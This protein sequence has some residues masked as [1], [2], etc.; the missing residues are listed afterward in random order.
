MRDGF[1]FTARESAALLG[2]T[3]VSVNSALQRARV[4]IADP[5]PAPSSDPRMAETVRL[6]LEAVEHD[7]IDGF[8]EMLRG[9]GPAAERHWTY[10]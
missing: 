5:P 3:T 4:S 10:A 1:G 7:D 9:D 8:I 6:Y 2:T